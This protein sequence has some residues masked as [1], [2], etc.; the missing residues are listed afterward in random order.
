MQE[1]SANIK[2]Q[3]QEAPKFATPICYGER[4]NEWKLL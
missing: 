4:E 2:P 3:S 1:T